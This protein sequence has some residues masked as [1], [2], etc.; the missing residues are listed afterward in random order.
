MING[1]EIYIVKLLIKTYRS[2]GRLRKR[3]DYTDFQTPESDDPLPPPSA[4]AVR[5]ALAMQPAA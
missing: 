4:Q 3:R 2:I 1:G 5:R